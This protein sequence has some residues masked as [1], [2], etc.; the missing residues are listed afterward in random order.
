MVSSVIGGAY[1]D[2]IERGDIADITA[3]WE[4]EGWYDKFPENFQKLSS[5]NGR[6]YFVPQAFQLNPIWYRK[7]VFSK[8]N[9]SPPDSW[10][11]LL[12][13]C[14]TLHQAG[15]QPFALAGES[16]WPL[17]LARWFTILNL[18][19]N[20]PEFHE[21]VSKGE[22]DFTDPRIK[23][24]FQYW[25]QLFDHQ[26]FSDS[27][28]QTGYQTALNQLVQGEAAMYNLGEWM[29]E[30][31]PVNMQTKLGFFFL[32]QIRTDIP[33]AEIVH[34]YGAFLMANNPHEAEAKTV[35]KFLGSKKSHANT[36]GEVNRLTPH[37]DLR[38][39][40]YFSKMQR[41][42]L[43]G[44]KDVDLLVPLL[45]FNMAPDMAKALLEGFRAFCDDRNDI[46][47][48]LAKLENTRR[49]LFQ[50]ETMPN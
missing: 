48:V 35:L 2:Y 18:R 17:P 5:H 43:T 7:D 46:D 1:R 41:D 4:A 22:V 11:A 36:A 38:P 13:I 16:R 9:L 19:L 14:D 15:Y 27:V 21:S 8:L 10:E 45:E 26:A 47:N 37:A 28:A 3:L 29:F 31:L 49:E 39:N 50:I 34:T 33:Q 20:G 44:I 12:T 6:Q 24:V 40:I 42:L 32:P 30:S 25:T 23:G